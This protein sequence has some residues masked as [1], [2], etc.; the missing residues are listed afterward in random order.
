MMLQKDTKWTS[1]L[2]YIQAVL[3]MI[4]KNYQLVLSLLFV[5]FFPATFFGSQMGN[6]W[7]LITVDMSRMPTQVF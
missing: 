3:C 7:N 6:D 2:Y 5:S 4:K 1:P